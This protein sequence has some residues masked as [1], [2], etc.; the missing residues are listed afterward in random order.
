MME[1]FSTQIGNIEVIEQ[2]LSENLDE[3]G[4]PLKRKAIK[5]IVQ[6]EVANFDIRKYV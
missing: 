6:D 4:Q 3:N 5:E 1:F 2:L